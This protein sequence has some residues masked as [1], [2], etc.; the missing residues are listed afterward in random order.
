MTNFCRIML[1]VII[2]AVILQSCGG[3]NDEPTN[4]IQPETPTNPGEPAESEGLTETNLIGVWENG[5]FFLSFNE[6]GYFS[7]CIDARFIDNG[8][9]SLND[10]VVTVN[11]PYYSRKHTYI[12]TAIDEKSISVTVNY[13]NIWS[14]EVTKDLKFS[15]SNE[16]PTEKDN[17]WYGKTLSIYSQTFGTITYDFF[18]YY[19]GKRSASKG[20]ASKYPISFYYV[21]LGN[22]FYWQYFTAG[23]I[24][25]I[26]SWNVNAGI[27]HVST[28]EKDDTHEN[29]STHLIE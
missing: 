11:N 5:D 9:Y 23:Q 20:S 22:K 25:S 3:G 6:D 8:K 27:I 7:G 26:G 1:T 13:T 24:P 19:S 29:F 10:D 12:I 17:P 28:Y 16:N 14:E 18:S 21:T 2:S 4:P 15:K